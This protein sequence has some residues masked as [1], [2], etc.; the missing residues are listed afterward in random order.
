MKL[1]VQ[2]VTSCEVYIGGNCHSRT[3]AGLL[4][5]FGTRMGDSE[6]H[7]PFL[8]DKLVN[9]RIFEDSDEKMNLSALDIHAE[10]M[11]VSQF[12]LYADTRKGR[13]PS[14]TEAMPPA[15]AEILYNHFVGLLKQTGLTVKT[16]VFGAKMDLTFTNH[17]PVTII[18]EDPLA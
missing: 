3:D 8:C 18:L 12:T 5:L 10:L 2:R 1:V 4:V 6:V 16:G 7:S 11:I 15:E 13:R 17:G 9:L 14:F